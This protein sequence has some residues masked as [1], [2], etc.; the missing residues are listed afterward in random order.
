MLK[1]PG[2]KPGIHD[3]YCSFPYRRLTS[4]SLGINADNCWSFTK[5]EAALKGV[6][7]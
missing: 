1:R 7:L 3:K 6:Y 5:A 4:L 2:W